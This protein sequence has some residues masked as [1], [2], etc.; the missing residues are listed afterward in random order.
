MTTL[1]FIDT[2]TTGLDAALGVDDIPDGM[3]LSVDEPSRSVRDVE[4][5]GETMGEI[6]MH[7]NMV[8]KGYL[9]DL[10]ATAKAL[11]GGWFRTGD[12]GVKHPD[13]YVQIKDRAKDIIIRNGENISPKEVE[14]LLIAHPAIAEIA[15]VTQAAHSSSAGPLSPHVYLVDDE[16]W[17]QLTRI[18]E[19][20]ISI[21]L[22][23]ESVRAFDLDDRG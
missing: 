21:M 1:C 4:R 9:K 20:T 18:E 11:S 10:P 17:H 12:L 16:G 15:K 7:G 14:D 5:D 2:E 22:G 19:G 23:R 6:V 8:A 13:G 3:F